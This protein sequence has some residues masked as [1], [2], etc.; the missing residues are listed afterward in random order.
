[1]G[2]D[3]LETSSARC[4]ALE[5]RIAELEAAVEASSQNGSD[6]STSPI[7]AMSRLEFKALALFRGD[8]GK[9]GN[10]ALTGA[11]TLDG[12]SPTRLQV[13]THGHCQPVGLADS[14]S[15]GCHGKLGR[16]A[17]STGRI[18]RRCS[19]IRPPRSRASL[20]WG[21]SRFR[22]LGSSAPLV[23]GICTSRG[24]AIVGRTTAFRWK[25]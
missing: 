20:D 19:S 2:G 5:A 4:Q 11:S 9:V 22:L 7:S 1:M 6:G 25:E 18:R 10:C 8:G 3:Q 16:N 21:S 15:D 24:P 14:V 13:L 17:R 23:T 12:S